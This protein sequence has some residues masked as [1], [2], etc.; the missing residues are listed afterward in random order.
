MGLFS[1]QETQ[2]PTEGSVSL[3]GHSVFK[4]PHHKDRGSL[5][6]KTPQKS[7]L[8]AGLETGHLCGV[9][10]PQSFILRCRD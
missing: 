3:R 9:G 8:R 1:R 6:R 2:G 10:E 7:S 5:V 4:G